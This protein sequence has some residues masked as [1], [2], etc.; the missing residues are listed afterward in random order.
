MRWA[1]LVCLAGIASARAADGP[2]HWHHAGI[3]PPGAIGRQRLMRGGPLSGYC[4][5]VEIRAPKGARIAP[6]SG[7]GF[8]EG[9][10][11]PLQVGLSIGAV[12]RFR[13]TDLPE[14]PG[15]ELFPTIEMVDRTYPPPGLA[16]KFP[17]P[18]ELTEDELML[19]AQGAFVT[20]VI[21]I[22]DPNLALP[23]AE[24]A[25]SSTRWMDVRPGEDPLVTAD[26]LGRPIAILRIGSRLP[27]ISGEDLAG[28]GCPEAVIYDQAPAAPAENAEPVDDVIQAY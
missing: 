6:L 20:R 4:Q 17:V 23:I 26:S 21:Y 8:T 1:V 27:S 5:R 19:A 9:Y 22:E 18:V 16:K 13:V 3:M 15:V 2:V 11:A 10:A 24:K 14:H 28:M 25:D 12:Y 7:G